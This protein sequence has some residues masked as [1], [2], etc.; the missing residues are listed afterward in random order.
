M[1]DDLRINDRVRVRESKSAVLF[2][3]RWSRF[4]SP[5]DI[6]TLIDFDGAKPVI[7]N[8]DAK[9]TTWWI[10]TFDAVDLDLVQRAAP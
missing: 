8:T 9:G 10:A 5:G 6:G 7:E 4:P 1:A 3:G 2:P